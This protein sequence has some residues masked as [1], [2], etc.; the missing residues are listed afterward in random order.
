MLWHGIFLVLLAGQLRAG[1][2][3]VTTWGVDEGLAQSSVTS[4]AQTPDGYLWVGT[5]LSGISRFDGVTFVNYDSANTPSLTSPGV[6]RLLVD[7]KGNLWLNDSAN[8]LL[9]RQGNAF[10]KVGEDMR[11][12]S[13]VSGKAGRVAFATA[14]CKCN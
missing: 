9:L 4:I 13:L 7:S 12:H 3:S 2:Y 5:R 11:L 6:R 8:D 10:V 14:A 1:E